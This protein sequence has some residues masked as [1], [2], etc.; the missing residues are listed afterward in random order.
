M[1]VALPPAMI[2]P[3]SLE[4]SP[5]VEQKKEII[6]FFSSISDAICALLV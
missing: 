5:V 3:F 2:V 4:A 1:G 6:V